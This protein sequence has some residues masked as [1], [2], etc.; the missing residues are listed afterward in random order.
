MN[1]TSHAADASI[2]WISGP[3]LRARTQRAMRINEAV[4]IANSAVLRSGE[5]ELVFVDQGDGRFEPRE[6]ELGIR[7]EGD[8]VQDDR[9]R[10]SVLRTDRSQLLIVNRKGDRQQF[11]IG[12]TERE[13]ISLVTAAISSSAEAYRITYATF[14]PLRPV[15]VAGGYR[16]TLTDGELTSLVVLTDG[17]SPFLCSATS[18]A[19]GWQTTLSSMHQP[20]RSAPC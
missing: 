9:I 19:L 13:Q 6:V 10:A 17:S 3:V 7:G 20:I 18:R 12:P 16:V 1:T 11:A 8:V 15:R 4:L 2:L 14:Q 5:R